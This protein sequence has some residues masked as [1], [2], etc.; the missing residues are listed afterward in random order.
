MQIYKCK[1]S[2][3]E[4]M[5]KYILKDGDTQLGYAYFKQE[6]INPIEIF[7]DEDKRSQGFGKELFV[8]MVKIAKEKG[9]NSLMFEIKN[10]NYRMINIIASFGGVPLG[11][12]NGIQKWMLPIKF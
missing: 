8:Q 6:K 10:E 4:D 2:D 9:L 11:T 1:N 7:I 3:R 5:E 12:F